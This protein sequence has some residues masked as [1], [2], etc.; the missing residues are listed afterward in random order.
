MWWWWW[1]S[2]QV[3]SDSWNPMDRSPPGSFVHGIFL[4]RILE[5]IAISS[6]RGLSR[7]R[8]WTRVACTA[9]RFSTIWAPGKQVTSKTKGWV[10][11]LRPAGKRH[12]SSW[13]RGFS[14]TDGIQEQLH[15]R[16]LRTWPGVPRPWQAPTPAGQPYPR[17]LQLCLLWGTHRPAQTSV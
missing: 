16:P 7:P 3:V 4:A 10:E 17:P 11:G 2:R 9:G 15:V 12:S 5:W 13:M 14:G 6:S 1:F 8:D